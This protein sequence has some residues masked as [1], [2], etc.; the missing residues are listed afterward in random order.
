M[1]RKKLALCAFEQ[2]TGPWVRADGT[3][4]E[5]HITPL[6]DG[7]MVSLEIEGLVGYMH[8]KTG[9]SPVQLQD[10]QM[11]RFHKTVPEDTKPSKTTVEVYLNGG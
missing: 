7:E 2:G 6:K 3:E 9:H 1:A 4:R 10:G 8:L 5:V 11:Y